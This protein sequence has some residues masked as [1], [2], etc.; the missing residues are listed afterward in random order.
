MNAGI[1]RLALVGVLA[2][3]GCQSIP[4]AADFESSRARAPQ[5]RSVEVLVDDRIESL[6]LAERIR[7]ATS[8]ALSHCGFE[9]SCPDAG[10]VVVVTVGRLPETP[11][12]RRP[13]SRPSSLA[14]LSR[15]GMS[16]AAF[17]N[18]HQP[19]IFEPPSGQGTRVGLL[20]SAIERRHLEDA[21]R[22]PEEWPR[23][24]R[25]FASVPASGQKWS[26]AGPI[27]V[28]SLRKCVSESWKP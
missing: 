7:Q 24:W 12:P 3:A 17:Q 6:A 27:L 8:E 9:S 11:A 13:A 2:L 21:T 19:S 1:H 20:W 10:L 14:A 5:D 15:E 22:P 18:R 4:E 26:T 25:A 16:Q 28:E 23:I